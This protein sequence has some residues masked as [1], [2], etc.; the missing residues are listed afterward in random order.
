MTRSGIGVDEREEVRALIAR[1]A[2]YSA[3]ERQLVFKYYRSDAPRVADSRLFIVGRRRRSS[4][5]AA[6][7]ADQRQL[8]FSFMGKSHEK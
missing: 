2:P 5:S 6:R 4:P 8:S 3:D 1:G 7:T